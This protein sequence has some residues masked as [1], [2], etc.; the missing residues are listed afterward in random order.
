M[1]VEKSLFFKKGLSYIKDKKSMRLKKCAIIYY[2]GQDSRQKNIV[3]VNNFDLY[4]L[5]QF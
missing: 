4:N 5:L 3:T 2:F 1:L